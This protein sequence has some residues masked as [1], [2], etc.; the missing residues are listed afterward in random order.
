MPAW[1]ALGEIAGLE[2]PGDGFPGE[3]IQSEHPVFGSF[4]A[5]YPIDGKR[6]L[7]DRSVVYSEWIAPSAESTESKRAD[8]LELLLVEWM[9]GTN[10]FSIW[11]DTLDAAVTEPYM[12]M[13]S[14]D[15]KSAGL[16]DGDRVSV[17]LDNGRLEIV[18]SVSNRT[19]EGVVIIPRHKLLDWQKIKD[20]FYRV[21]PGKIRKI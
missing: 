3:Y 11:S 1:K 2:I 17:E 6:V 18:L 9:F 5:D 8:G 15:A 12:S 13:N 19:A 21:L 4:G 20:S 10:E 7:Q 16:S 14:K